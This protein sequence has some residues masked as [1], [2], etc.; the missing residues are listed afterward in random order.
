M[1]QERNTFKIIL[2]GAGGC[3]KTNFVKRLQKQNFDPKYIPTLGVEV[4]PVRFETN[5]GTYCLNVWDCAGDPKFGGLRDGYYVQADACIIMFD[6]TSPES[7]NEMKR[8]AV[9][10]RRCVGN[11]PVVLCGNKSDC[12]VNVDDSLLAQLRNN[13]EIIYFDVSTKNNFHVNEPCIELLR[14]LT[15]KP[16][17]ELLEN[18]K[19][20]MA[21]ML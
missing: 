13:P 2:V 4:E 19:N 10:V 6:L 12:Q 21:S 20:N 5:Y 9:D 7:L 16:N 15:K 3:G 14:I 8:V 17:L 1:Q 11:V 18:M